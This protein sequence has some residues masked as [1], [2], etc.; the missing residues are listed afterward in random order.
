[1]KLP[2]PCLQSAS[3]SKFFMIFNTFCYS[4]LSP[5]QPF[6]LRILARPLPALLA[7]WLR[8]PERQS[9]FFDL[10][11]HAAKLVIIVKQPALGR[12]LLGIGWKPLFQV[13]VVRANMNCRLFFVEPNFGCL[14]RFRKSRFDKIDLLIKFFLIFKSGAF[15]GN[16]SRLLTW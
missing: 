1:M 5:F 3:Q 7:V 16:F 8:Q 15:F 12:E 11:F 2:Y 13:S 6:L 4:I 14:L 9:T 10:K